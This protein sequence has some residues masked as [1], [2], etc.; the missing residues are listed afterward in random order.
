MQSRRQ[1]YPVT[2]IGTHPIRTNLWQKRQQLTCFTLVTIHSRGEASLGFRYA[3][4]SRREYIP[5]LSTAH[6]YLHSV[7][8]YDA[9]GL[10]FL[11]RSSFRLL[12]GLET[13]D[14]LHRDCDS[15]HRA[16]SFDHYFTHIRHECM[17]VILRCFHAHCT[18][19]LLF[20]RVLYSS[21]CNASDKVLPL[22]FAATTCTSVT[23]GHR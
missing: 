11:V 16:L 12:Q 10:G 1:S 7:K 22:R 14:F 8:F 6:V 4:L 15:G 23:N 2:Q 17:S 5:K 21:R 13:V 20:C 19:F 18:Q 9:A 3:S